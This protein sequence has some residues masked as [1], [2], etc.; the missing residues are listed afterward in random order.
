MA[1]SATPSKEVVASS[2]NCGELMAQADLEDIQS[3]TS[4]KDPLPRIRAILDRE[5]GDPAK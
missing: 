4:S 2:A 1:P 5:G 3:A